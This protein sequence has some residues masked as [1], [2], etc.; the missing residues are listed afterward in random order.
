MQWYDWLIVLGPLLFVLGMGVYVQRYTKAN[1][2][3]FLV[4]GR[5]CGRYVILVGDIAGALS[6]VTMLAYIEVKY[7]TGFALSFW[8]NFMLPLTVVM[9]LTGYCTYRFRETR[10]MSLGQFL[11]MRYSRPFRI[12]AAA[13]RSI[14]EMLTNMIMPALAARFFIYF[15][16]LPRHFTVFGLQVS[17]FMLILVIALF[18]AIF[19]IWMGGTLAVVITDSLQGMILYPLMVIF[20]IFV[21]VKFSWSSEIIPVIDRKSVV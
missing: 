20:V 2:A 3:N 19:I 8:S 6:F 14:S 16:D 4:A 12:F 9:G 5:V 7:K 17:T 11:E 18:M 15:L 10:A 1:V 13:L 21:L